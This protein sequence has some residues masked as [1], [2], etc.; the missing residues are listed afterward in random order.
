MYRKA[1]K[2]T[3]IARLLS[4]S[5]I[6]TKLYFY[7]LKT[8]ENATAETQLSTWQIQMKVFCMAVVSAWTK[9]NFTSCDCSST[10]LH[11]PCSNTPPQTLRRKMF[12]FFEPYKLV[13]GLIP[14]LVSLKKGVGSN[15]ALSILF[16][17]RM[18]STY[19][20]STSVNWD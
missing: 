14:R 6:Q 7:A 17:S 3:L 1:S 8:L 4:L 20:L 16:F 10:M 2:L 19:H 9:V 13:G 18:L 12:I 15:L 11:C 5:P